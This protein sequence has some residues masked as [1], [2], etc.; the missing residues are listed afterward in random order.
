MNLS[1]PNRSLRVWRAGNG[2]D[3]QPRVQRAEIEPTVEA[4]RE[5]GEVS[6]RI[7]S[8]VE[9]MVTAG[10]AGLRLPSTVLIHRNSGNSFGLRPATTVG[11]CAQP[12][13]VTALKQANPSENTVLP[14]RG[15][16]GPLCD[17]LEGEACTGVSLVRKGCPSSL[18]ETAATK[19]TLFCEP[20][21]TL[22]PLRSP[23]RQASS[24]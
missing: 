24:T 17:R 11:W 8:E 16:S 21:P 12:A 18:S 22:P 23:P 19:G 15:Q 4:I 9:R 6:S 7:L 10:E 5:G 2:G 1:Q 13:S 3:Q 20:R 14:G